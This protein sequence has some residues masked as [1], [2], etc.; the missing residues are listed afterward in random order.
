MSTLFRT[1][2]SIPGCA[3]FAPPTTHFTSVEKINNFKNTYSERHNEKDVTFRPITYLSFYFL[4]I[5]FFTTKRLTFQKK[6]YSLHTGHCMF[7]LIT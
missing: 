6:A 2:T 7:S 3:S 1:T 4:S 5:L